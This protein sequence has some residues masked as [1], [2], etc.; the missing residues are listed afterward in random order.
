MQNKTN[1]LKNVNWQ[2]VFKVIKWLVPTFIAFVLLKKF[3]INPNITSNQLINAIEKLEWYWYLLLPV[4]ACLNW[5]VETRKW[6]YLICKLELQSFKVAFKSV[7]SGVAVSQLL[8]YRTGEYLGRLAYVEDDNKLQAGF[9][10]IIGSFSQLLMTLV[11]GSIAFLIIEPITIPGNFILSSISLVITCLILIFII[12]KLR[13]VQHSKL[14]Q[15][16]VVSIKI[17]KLSDLFRLV[18]FSFLRYCLFL[19]PY[20]LLAL[21]FDLITDNNIL[22]SICSIACIFL[23]QTISPNFILTD[24]AIRISVPALVFSGSLDTN[25]GTEYIPGFIIYIFNVVI[26]MCIGAL[27]LLS[28]KLK[29]Q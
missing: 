29:K 13:I 18:G 11:F 3:F 24:I 23:L 22:T 20:A 25:N 6:Q 8:P 9:L 17:L 16:L 28:L 2:L 14:Y 1:I 5:A 26:P 4:F 10:S 12:P 27:I 7:L 15:A 21:Q 19:L